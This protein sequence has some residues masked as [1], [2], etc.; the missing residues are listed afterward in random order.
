MTIFAYTDEQWTGIKTIVFKR[1]GRDADE[2]ERA[3]PA[4]KLMQMVDTLNATMS[5]R[6]ALEMAASSYIKSS[7]VDGQTPGYKARIKKLEAMRATADALHKDLRDAIR[8]TFTVGGD[9]IVRQVIFGDVNIDPF[10][11]RG[12]AFAT[13]ISVIDASIA[14]LTARP[15]QQTANS[16]KVGRDRFW[17]EMLAIWT[18]VGG[19]E[20]G[21]AAA[22]WLVATSNAVFDRVWEIRGRKTAI[23]VSYGDNDTLAPVIEWLRL[24]AKAR[25]ATS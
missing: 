12:P 21:T 1:L 5:L 15:P 23:S 9:D 4:G 7:A 19:A 8:P 25:Q 6:S 22:E 17:N 18:G 13:V 20:K 24:R 11:E 3:R 14:S 2:I 16:R 10:D